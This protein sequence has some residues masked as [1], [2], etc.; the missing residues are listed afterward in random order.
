MRFWTSDPHFGHL[1][2]CELAN[3]PFATL[4]E[5]HNVLTER[6]NNTVTNDD[7]VFVVGDICMGP[8]DQSL[9]LL[10]ALNGTIHLTPGNHDHVH[11]ALGENRVNK[12]TGPYSE[13]MEIL[14]PQWSTTIGSIDFDVCHFPFADDGTGLITDSHGDDRYSDLRPENRGQYLICGHSHVGPEDAVQGNMVNVGVDAWDFT[15]ITDA[16]ILGALGL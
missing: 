4:D 10:E 11:P 9:Q 16:Q 8:R 6:W 13:R 7:D 2:I 12:W 1:R 3:R 15:P 5:M 14:P